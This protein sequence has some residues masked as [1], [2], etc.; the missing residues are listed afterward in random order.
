[1]NEEIVLKYIGNGAFI[2][3]IPAKDLTA[4]EVKEYGGVVALVATGLYERVAV[5]PEAKPAKDGK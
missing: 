1:M 5:K 2:I 3:G 4:A